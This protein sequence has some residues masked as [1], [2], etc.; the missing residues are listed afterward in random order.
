MSEYQYYEFLAI[1]RPLN[2]AEIKRLRKLSTRAEITATR[3]TNT[4]HWGDF[5]G[6]P[7]NMIEKY[8]DA[9]VYVANWGSYHFVLRFPRGM[10]DEDLLPSYCI[11]DPFSFR[12][13]DEHIIIGWYL[14]SEDGGEWVSEG[15]DWMSQLI[16]IRNEIEQGDYRSLYIGF[17]LAISIGLPDEDT[18]EPPV[19][20]GLAS[21]T[22]TQQSLINFLEID[23]D[24]VAA[25]ATASEPLTPRTDQIKDMRACIEQLQYDEMK[26]MLLRVLSGESRGV[27][28]E[29][30]RRY[31]QFLQ[32]SRPADAEDGKHPRR[33]VPELFALVEAARQK[34]LELE[35]RALERK[36]A[37]EERKRRK[38]LA[39]LATQFPENWEKVEGLAERQIASSYA[40]AVDLLMDLSDAYDQM[41]CTRE[42]V[43]Q[44]S[45]FL[46]R[47]QRRTALIRRMKE[48]GLEPTVL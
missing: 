39:E 22:A 42:F 38:Y 23:E 36:R 11:D 20:P 8:F 27:E 34:R 24:L 41:G 46:S 14:D 45:Q 31:N 6:S 28:S 13:T 48:A 44:F 10:I 16:Q 4:Y 19:P 3:F 26:Q 47:H 43:T 2:S 17:L 21:P 29:L 40:E 32:Q 33:I 5:H 35:A 7:E 18:M 1:D 30:H 37:A 15:E 12:T 9:H 25:A